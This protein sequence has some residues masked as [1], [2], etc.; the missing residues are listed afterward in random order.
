MQIVRERCLLRLCGG[1]G[2]WPRLPGTPVA[3]RDFN[4][5]RHIAIRYW[6]RRRIIYN[7]ALVPPAIFSYGFIDNLKKFSTCDGND[8]RGVFL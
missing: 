5:F 1:L 6:E 8:L 7:L 2:S 4:K 3:M